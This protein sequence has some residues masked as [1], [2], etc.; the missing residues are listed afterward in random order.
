MTLDRKRAYSGSTGKLNYELQATPYIKDTWH[1]LP[2]TDSSSGI[3]DETEVS[4]WMELKDR[5]PKFSAKGP[6]KMLYQVICL[7]GMQRI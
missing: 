3:S 2:M 6:A 5:L 7:M 4:N 1:E